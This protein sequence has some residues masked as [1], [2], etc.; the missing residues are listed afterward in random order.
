MISPPENFALVEPGLYRSGLPGPHNFPFVRSL[1][2]RRVIILSPERPL[3]SIT[4][5]FDTHGI[6]V[7]HTGLTAWTGQSTWKPIAEE[8]VK[9]SLEIIL[10][11]DQY[12][13]LVCDVGGVHLV[14]M[15][16]GCLRRLQNWNL[17]SVVN[18]YRSFAGA[19]TRYV[20]E[21]FIE[22]FDIDLVTIPQSPPLWFAEQLQI[23][24]MEH[25]EYN[26]LIDQHCVDASGALI[27]G[28][29]FPSYV[30]YYYSSASP[31]NSQMGGTTPRIETFYPSNKLER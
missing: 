14:G 2:L 19:K 29:A 1:R 12:P 21:Q 30:I 6:S 13:V 4:N 11:E 20:N 17:N 9:D 23:D 15:V 18:E 25:D 3:R 26:A 22:L 16:I 8:V 31:L 7:S 28:A 27:N 5:F 10:R 24:K